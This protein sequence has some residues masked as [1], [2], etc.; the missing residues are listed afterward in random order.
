MT[1]VVCATAERRVAAIGVLLWLALT[2]AGCTPG[3]D[4]APASAATAISAVAR[5]VESTAPIDP[6]RP[7][8]HFA[9]AR[10]WVNDPNGPVLL[11]GRYHLFYQFNPGGISWGNIAWGHASS[12]DL[13][14]WTEHPVAI[15]RTDSTMIFSG[16]VV[17]DSMGSAGFCSGPMC[18]VA[19]YTAAH[20]Q[21]RRQSQSLAYSSDGGTT[22]SQYAANPVLD[23]GSQEFR[24]PYVFWHDQSRAW[25]MVVAMSTQHVV[26]IYRST[27]LRDWLLSS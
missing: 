17:V 18:L 20:E 23:I 15:P 3:T 14:A 19:I 8:I 6:Y 27:T 12:S 2:G 11:N 10:H 13:L 22:W 26:R 7:L 21:T 25:I 24:D 1:C 5:S 9:P 4:E 16:G